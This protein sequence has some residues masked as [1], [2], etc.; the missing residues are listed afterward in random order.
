MS[1]ENRFVKPANTPIARKWLSSRHVIA[2]TIEELLEETFSVQS[3]P[4]LYNEDQL[5][6][7]EI[8]ETATRRVGGWCESGSRGTSTVGR[9]Y[10]AAQ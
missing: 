10:Q 5:R 1:A 7:R 8:P 3:V 9:R 6:L 2:A 4:S